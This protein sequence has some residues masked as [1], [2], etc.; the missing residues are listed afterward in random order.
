MQAPGNHTEGQSEPDAESEDEVSAEGESDD[1]L[2]RAGDSASK[3]LEAAPHA[4]FDLEDFDFGDI[5]EPSAFAQGP[6]VAS[7]HEYHNPKGVPVQGNASYS[8][9]AISNDHD[10]IFSTIPSPS[11]GFP[12]RGQAEHSRQVLDYT[13]PSS[14]RPLPRPPKD[15]DAN[16]LDIQ[17]FMMSDGLE[18]EGIV[19]STNNQ[20]VDFHS[21]N[22]YSGQ[23]QGNFPPT[24]L[25]RGS[26]NITTRKSSLSHQP[27]MSAPYLS[28]DLGRHK[29]IPSSVSPMQSDQ[30]SFGGD[31]TRRVTISAICSA[32]QL[33]KLIQAVTEQTISA[34]F[35]TGN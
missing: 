7:M 17:D 20:L 33:G 25:S 26:T 4:S 22:L 5:A 21:S 24:P 1:G 29:Q 35:E 32:D 28:P 8:E 2:G 23:D 31:S 10:Y 9:S 34:K 3:I 16:M 15:N 14:T 13:S 12:R 18:N 6:P 30:G 27:R 11:F 19:S